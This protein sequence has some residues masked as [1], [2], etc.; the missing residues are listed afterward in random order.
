MAMRRTM[1]VPLDQGLD[2]YACPESDR[3]EREGMIRTPAC[4]IGRGVWLAAGILAGVMLIG[5]FVWIW[6]RVPPFLLP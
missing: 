1:E 2:D 5:F 3:M 4:L 6:L